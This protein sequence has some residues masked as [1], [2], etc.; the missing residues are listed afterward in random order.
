MKAC[1]LGNSS[2]FRVLLALLVVLFPDDDVSVS[3]DVTQLVAVE[4]DQQLPEAGAGRREVDRHL[5]VFPGSHG[6]AQPA[7]G[8]QINFELLA[9]RTVTT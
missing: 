7:E 8:L 9:H 2:G 1:R 6:A 5:G 3:L 4:V